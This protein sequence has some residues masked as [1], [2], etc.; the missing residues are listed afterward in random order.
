MK[1]SDSTSAMVEEFLGRIRIGDVPDLDGFIADHPAADDPEDLRGLL[2]TLLDVERLTFSSAKA[3]DD[4]PLPD[5]TPS[6]YRLLKKIGAGGMGI[7]YEALQIDLGRHVAVKLIRPELLT[8]PEIQKLFQVEARI[9]ARFDHP[10]IVRILGAGQCIDNFFYVM[11]LSKGRQLDTLTGRP[12]ERQLLQWAVEASDALACAHSHGIVHGDIKPANL[13]LDQDGHLRICDFGLAFTAQS[14]QN[15]RKLPAGTLRYMAPELR[16]G[17]EKTFAGDQY[18]LCAALV[19]IATAKPF[20]PNADLPTPLHDA[21]LAAV[22][23]KGLERTPGNRYH[24][25]CDLRDDLMRIVRHDPVAAQPPSLWLRFRLFSQRHPL[26]VV[27]AALLIFCLI[28]VVH[29]LVR[30]EAA[31]ELALRNAETANAALGKVFDEIVEQ[32]P[33]PR[34]AELLAQLVPHYEQIAAN[35]NIPPTELTGA[36]SQLAKTAIRT[37]DYPL[38][39]RTLRRLLELDRS[40]GHLCRLADTLCQQGSTNEATKL[41]RTIIERHSDGSPAERLDAVEAR[42]YLL[43]ASQDGESAAYRQYARQIL[44]ECLID[45]P[46][47]D[48]AL[49]LYAQ[50]L[51]TSGASIEPI[52]GLPTNP[53]EIL[54]EISTRNPNNGRY[55]QAF[56]DGTAN[57]L[58]TVNGTN[59]CPE[60][61]ESALE[62]SD[63]TLWRFLNRPHTVS[64]ALSLKRAFARWQQ[65]SMMPFGRRRTQISTDTLTHALLNQPNLPKEDQIDLIDLSLDALENPLMPFR[66]NRTHPPIPIRRIKKL[67]DFL[68]QHQLPRSEEFL[69]RIQ[70]LEDASEPPGQP[71][72]RARRPRFPR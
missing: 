37:G 26:H 5:L 55:W 65:K 64:S 69:Q 31:L 60:V 67:K 56:I 28:S 62:K 27:T 4:L 72:L 68:L 40:S 57:W 54:D 71:P 32:P 14:R 10:G 25:I 1:T 21:Q 9:L 47:N 17:Q 13:L 51:L 48:K 53:L 58:K 36:L 33:T 6:G 63:I 16:H 29:G 46:M 20:D 34:N 38:A 3:G 66:G 23:N 45:E 41:Y 59:G 35:P 49:F 2:S 11:E 8:D 42:L 19:E 22:L 39:E 18:A 52:S 15:S 24:A 50:L 70:A 43:K 12:D 44:A 7:V 30:T 61:I